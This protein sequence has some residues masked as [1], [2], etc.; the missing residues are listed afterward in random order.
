M[1]TQASTQDKKRVNTAVLG[2]DPGSRYTG[3]A[4]I[5]FRGTSFECRASGVWSL[6]KE[7]DEVARLAKL[8]YE[9]DHLLSLHPCVGLAF[10]DAFYAKN[11]Q[12]LLKLGRLQGAVIS[13]GNK[14]KLLMSRYAPKSIKQAVGGSGQASKEIVTLRCRLLLNLPPSQKILLDEGD[15]MAIALCHLLRNS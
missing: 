13:S 14:H 4:I 5:A 7:V 2:I 1:P 10:E 8:A 11:A 9:I 12:V 3:Y 6:H 15:A